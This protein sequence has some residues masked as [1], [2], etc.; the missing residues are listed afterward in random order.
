MTAAMAGVAVGAPVRAQTPGLTASVERLKQNIPALF[1]NQQRFSASS[2]LIDEFLAQEYAA[3]RD[4]FGE[5]LNVS[6]F[7]YE[8]MARAQ[9]PEFTALSGEDLDATRLA[10]DAVEPIKV[11][12]DILPKPDDTRVEVCKDIL[13]EALGLKFLGEAI[14]TLI[15]ENSVLAQYFDDFVYRLGLRDVPG[16]REALIALVYWLMSEPGLK[17][18]QKAVGV[19]PIGQLR[20]RVIAALG[21]RLVPVVG[22]TFTGACLAA[23]VYAHRQRLTAV[24]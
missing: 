20:R 7:D 9:A 2:A 13:I 3:R 8:T 5:V 17:A 16:A 4:F 1:E 15:K 19:M 23:C 21:S 18:L 11:L 10:P 22:W 6:E 14:G 24:F 12:R